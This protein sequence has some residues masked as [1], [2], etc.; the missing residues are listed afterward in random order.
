MK[1]WVHKG[2]IKFVITENPN[3][4]PERIYSHY[5][6]DTL[7]LLR[8]LELGGAVAVKNAAVRASLL[9]LGFFTPAPRVRIYGCVNA[10]TMALTKKG[11]LR[12]EEI[13]ASQRVSKSWVKY[14]NKLRNRVINKN[15]TL[16]G[17]PTH[18]WYR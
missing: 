11:K 7:Y 9:K 8:A 6:S 1:H 4:N 12:A 14:M 13:Q 10:H 2:G 3:P 18:W 16:Q 5:D 17:K 15:D